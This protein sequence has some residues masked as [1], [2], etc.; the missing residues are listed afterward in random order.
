MYNHSP[1]FPK[2]QQ[3]KKNCNSVHPSVLQQYYT[4]MIDKD[5]PK[6]KTNKKRRSRAKSSQREIQRRPSKKRKKNV[7]EV[8]ETSEMTDDEDED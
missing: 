1:V 6:P 7:R 8:S 4:I 3:E 5:S 2:K